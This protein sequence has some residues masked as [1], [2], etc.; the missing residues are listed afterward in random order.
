VHNPHDPEAQ[1]STKKGLGKAGWV[2]AKIQFCETAPEKKRDKGEPTQA[3]ITAVVTQPAITSDHGSLAGVLAAHEGSG[4][5]KPDEVFADAGYISAPALEKAKSDGYELCG[6]IGAPPY[7]SGRFG[8]DAFAIDLTNR[9]ATCPT[10]KT[11]HECSRITEAAR[12]A[13]TYYYFAWAQAD[14]ANCSLACQCL[15]MKKRQAFR[16]L[17]VG[18]KHMLVQT[19][20]NLCKTNEYQERMRRRIGIEG[21]NSECKRGYGMRRAR[22]RGL[23]GIDVQMQV[24]GAACNLRRWAARR[25]WLAAQNVAKTT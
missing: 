16:T 20:R 15:S 18:D 24:T 6:P 10:G 11:S 19:R 8:S 22:Y 17:Q 2:G 5:S 13:G 4:Q 1:W 7:S 25:C 3:V 14:C 12:T 9:T 21:T 23:A